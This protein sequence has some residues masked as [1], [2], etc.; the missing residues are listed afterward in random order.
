MSKKYDKCFL[1]SSDN[2]F[3]SA[4]RRAR[5]LNN[6]MQVIICPPPIGNI[7]NTKKAIWRIKDLEK[8][9]E[10]KPLIINWKKIKE[11][12]FDNQFDELEN[13]WVKID[14]PTKQIV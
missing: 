2:D 6:S 11:A 13:P 4:I 9:C 10:C 8:A 14:C 12:Q 3:S 5:E 7:K 1:L